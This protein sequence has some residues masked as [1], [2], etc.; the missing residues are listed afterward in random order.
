MEKI[1]IALNLAWL[2]LCLAPAL[3]IIA[4]L[5]IRK[6]ARV[7]TKSISKQ[8]YKQENTNPKPQNEPHKH[9]W[10]WKPWKYP[11]DSLSGEDKTEVLNS[12]STKY[13]ERFECSGCG[14][15]KDKFIVSNT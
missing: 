1:I 12:W 9:S 11:E 4:F 5:L 14:E 7:T 10:K 3:L 6:G 15:K 8:T 2:Y 13:H